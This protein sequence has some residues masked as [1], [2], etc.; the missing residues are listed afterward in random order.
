MVDTSSPSIVEN[1]SPQ[2]Q[3][4]QLDSE[5]GTS[6]SCRK[7]RK[8]KRK[9][10]GSNCEHAPFHGACFAGNFKHRAESSKA[11][12]AYPSRVTKRVRALSVSSRNNIHPHR[13]EIYHAFLF[14][15]FSS[16]LPSSSSF[17]F[18]FFF[19]GVL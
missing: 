16:T 19:N 5:T 9:K 7:K 18:F 4:E 10:R 2:W 1:D 14:L 8:K 11:T 15:S 12:F 3:R 17:F 6:S 13:L